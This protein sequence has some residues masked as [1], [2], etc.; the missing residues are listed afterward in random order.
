MVYT[1]TA[2]VIL[3]LIMVASLGAC[4][5]TPKDRFEDD[6][7]G[8]TYSDTTELLTERKTENPN[9]FRVVTELA[10]EDPI[11]LE[12]YGKAFEDKD[13]IVAP[14]PALYFDE[15]GQEI[16]KEKFLEKIKEN[17]AGEGF[18]EAIKKYYQFLSESKFEEAFKLVNAKSPFSK[19][20][21]DNLDVFK[22]Q[23]ESTRNAIRYVEAYITDCKLTTQSYPVFTIDVYFKI[24]GFFRNSPV[25]EKPQ[26]DNAPGQDPKRMMEDPKKKPEDLKKE[27]EKLGWDFRYSG[28]SKL[29]LAYIGGKWLIHE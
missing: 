2:A 12:A 29:T 21:F 17:N 7:T 27:M 5:D 3:A 26:G 16:K 18:E 9:E 13:K 8:K 25:I 4:G 19:T 15:N 6:R 1:K 11:A 20:F 23:Q 22:T 24:L 14:A 10:K 28:V